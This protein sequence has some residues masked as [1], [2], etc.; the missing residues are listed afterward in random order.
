M[1]VRW[2]VPLKLMSKLLQPIQIYP[3]SLPIIMMQLLFDCDMYCLMICAVSIMIPSMAAG[4]V[5][6]LFGSAQ[7]PMTSSFCTPA[8]P[9]AHYITLILL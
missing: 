2:I 7:G 5:V 6:T 1:Q 3:T 8:A 4:S 9:S